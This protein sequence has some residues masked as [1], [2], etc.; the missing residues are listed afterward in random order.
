MPNVDGVVTS[1]MHLPPASV[2]AASGTFFST[3]R[4]LVYNQSA[5]PS[6]VRQGL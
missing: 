1:V 6:T 4:S 5:T 3:N 2:L